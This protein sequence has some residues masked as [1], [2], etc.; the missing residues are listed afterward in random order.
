MSAW[1]SDTPEAADPTPVEPDRTIGGGG[2]QPRGNE[3]F[4]RTTRALRAAGN[5]V[6]Y[7]HLVSAMEH[8][9]GFLA[10]LRIRVDRALKKAFADRNGNVLRN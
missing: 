4:D 7:L 9:F 2:G 10:A 6:E 8:R 1:K 5:A 3:I